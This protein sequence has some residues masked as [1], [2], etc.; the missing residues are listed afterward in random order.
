MAKKKEFHEELPTKV[1]PVCGQLSMEDAEVCDECGHSFVPTE[2]AEE[3]ATPSEKEDME[4]LFA[5][6]ENDTPSEPEPVEEPQPEPIEELDFAEEDPFEEPPEVPIEEFVEEPIEEIF[7]GLKCPECGTEI[8]EETVFCPVCG[9]QLKDGE[10]PNNAIIEGLSDSFSLVE[11][12][13]IDFTKAVF[14]EETIVRKVGD[15]YEALTF[16][17]EDAVKIIEA[18][19]GEAE[20]LKADYIL[21]KGV[22]I[23]TKDIVEAGATLKSNSQYLDKYYGNTDIDDIYGEGVTDYANIKGIKDEILD[24]GLPVNVM[25]ILS[26]L[27]AKAQTDLGE[28]M[29]RYEIDDLTPTSARIIVDSDRTADTMRDIIVREKTMQSIVADY[30]DRIMSR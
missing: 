8:D 29:K 9:A 10:V 24:I 22:D 23:T 30:V 25:Q 3:A 19:D 1:C 4:V 16:P 11:K 28:I 17:K 6:L 12:S 27:G 5:A 2:E 7:D 26:E 21:R 14:G 13:E 20:M 15:K 18:T